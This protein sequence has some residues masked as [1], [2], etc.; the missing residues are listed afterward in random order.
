LLC[1]L[2]AWC[3]EHYQFFEEKTMS[4]P[5]SIA[6]LEEGASPEDALYHAM[7][8]DTQMGFVAISAVVDAIRENVADPVAFIRSS[9]AR[10]GNE[11]MDTVLR[12]ESRGRGL[13]VDFNPLSALGM[14]IARLMGTDAARPIMC[15]RL[16]MSFGFANCCKVL[17]SPNNGDVHFSAKEQILW[18]HAIDC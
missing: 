5:S 9:L 13:C 2:V 10:F 14:Q 18:Q 15:D 12:A 4:F 16:D 6:K 17:A 1:G 3:N 7:Q 8:T 11:A